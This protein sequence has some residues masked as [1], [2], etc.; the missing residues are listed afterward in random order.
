MKKIEIDPKEIMFPAPRE[1]CVGSY[2]V[3]K[4]EKNEFS[5]I[6]SG[7]SRGLGSFLLT[8]NKRRKKQ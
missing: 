7:P 1:V 4:K 3:G 6:V 2:L 5:F 8:N